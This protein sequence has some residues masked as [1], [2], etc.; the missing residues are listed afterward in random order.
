MFSVHT[1]W[2][3][4]EFHTIFNE[5]DPEREVHSED[6][7]DLPILEEDEEDESNYEPMD[8]FHDDDPPLS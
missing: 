3:I 2:C 4:L 5:S 7:C 6:E 1:R 8:D